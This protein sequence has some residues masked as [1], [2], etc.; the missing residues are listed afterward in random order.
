MHFKN[1]SK[2]ELGLDKIECLDIQY[3]FKLPAKGC[4]NV[5]L[6]QALLNVRS[7]FRHGNCEETRVEETD[8]SQFFFPKREAEA[9]NKAANRLML[10]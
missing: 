2:S 6:F 5:D 4:L 8:S 9:H 7:R 3:N 10:K 1:T